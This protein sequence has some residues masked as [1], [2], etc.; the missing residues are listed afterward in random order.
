MIIPSPSTPVREQERR[1]A[2]KQE[3]N[4]LQRALSLG[5]TPALTPETLPTRWPHARRQR[6]AARSVESGE[7]VAR[8]RIGD[9]DRLLKELA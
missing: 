4:A 6:A 9:L 7:R 8:A 3:R 5:H 1:R 2:L